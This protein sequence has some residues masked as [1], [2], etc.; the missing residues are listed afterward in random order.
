[1]SAGENRAVYCR[2][3]NGT[4]LALKVTP[5]VKSSFLHH[6]LPPKTETEARWEATGLHILV[7]SHN[8]RPT[9][10]SKHI[11][12]PRINGYL[13]AKAQ[14]LCCTVPSLSRLI[15]RSARKVR[16]STKL[17]AIVRQKSREIYNKTG[18]D[19]NAGTLQRWQHHVPV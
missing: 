13:P 7:R 8:T 6:L 5:A 16:G 11:K 19:P 2:G 9:M 1:M 4:F 3:D 10:I 12:F 17:Q 14:F 18:H 15:L